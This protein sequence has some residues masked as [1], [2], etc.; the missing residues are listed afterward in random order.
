MAS[1]RALNNARTWTFAGD[2]RSYLLCCFS[3]NQSSD[4]KSSA[5]KSETDAE[6]AQYL[7]DIDPQVSPEDAAVGGSGNQA[8]GEIGDH[9][10]TGGGLPREGE[11]S[12]DGARTSGLFTAAG[13]IH[14]QQNRSQAENELR[15]AVLLRLSG[16]D[17]T[18]LTKEAPGESLP[19]GVDPNQPTIH[20]KHG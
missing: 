16:Y 6:L 19:P 14:P 18:D 11:E 15:E 2:L 7:D 13:E 4:K 10:E 9:S 1:V 8:D 17:P 3:F 20:L 12:T 5:A